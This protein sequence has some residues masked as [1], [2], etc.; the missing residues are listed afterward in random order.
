MQS[1]RSL[2]LFQ[3][4]IIPIYIYYSKNI[5]NSFTF[6]LIKS[7]ETVYCLAAVDQ[8][9]LLFSRLFKP[10]ESVVRLSPR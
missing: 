6:I 1:I 2:I 9:F 10:Y 5:D 8:I 3:N 7:S 4:M